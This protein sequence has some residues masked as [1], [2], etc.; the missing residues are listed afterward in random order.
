MNSFASKADVSFI[1][2]SRQSRTFV[3]QECI[4]LERQVSGL[5]PARLFGVLVVGDRR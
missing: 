2:P 1:D 4:T 5:F 3:Q